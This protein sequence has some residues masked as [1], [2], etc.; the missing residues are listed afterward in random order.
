[1]KLASS[2][3]CTSAL[4]AFVFSSD[5]LRNRCFFGRTEG[6]M[7]RLCSMTVR[8]NPTRSRAYQAKTSLFPG[9]TGDEFLLVLRSQVFAYDDCLLGHCRVKGNCLRSVIALQLCL[10]MFVGGWAGS[11]GDFAL[12]RKAV[13][14]L[15]TGNEVS[16]NVTR[17]LLVLVHRYYALWTQN[18][19]AEV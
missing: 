13:Y 5:I 1:M 3:R 6:S 16:L 18:F 2:R 4:A 9:E 15:L 7:P 19:H 12:R 11:L 17:S 8:L 14:V 10:F